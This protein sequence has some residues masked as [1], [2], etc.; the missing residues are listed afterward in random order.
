MGEYLGTFSFTASGPDRRGDHEGA[1]KGSPSLAEMDCRRPL[2]VWDGFQV[3][4]AFAG[5]PLGAG[6]EVED[7]D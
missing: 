5:G 7:F 4:E 3:G 2:A 6:R 1:H